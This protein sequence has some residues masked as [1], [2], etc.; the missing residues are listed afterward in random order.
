MKKIVKNKNRFKRV[1][2]Y[3]KRYRGYLLL[4]ALA[5]VGANLLILINPY[6]LK[7]AF[8]K[9]ETGAESSEIIKYA[10]FF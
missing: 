6:I 3:L 10:I 8:D 1:Y 4:G 2:K 7:L 9:L 5:I